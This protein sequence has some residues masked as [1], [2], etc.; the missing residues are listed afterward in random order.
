MQIDYSGL[1]TSLQFF[2]TVAAASIP[3]ML[4]YEWVE[5]LMGARKN[6]KESKT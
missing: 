3:V 5:L 4:A 6:N 2:I 1:M